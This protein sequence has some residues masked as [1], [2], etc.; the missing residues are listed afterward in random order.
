MSKDTARGELE[1][2]LDEHLRPYI[3]SHGGIVEVVDFDT[4]SGVVHI[5]ME[6][7]CSGCPA[8]LVTLRYGI[9]AALKEYVSWV[10]RV[11]LVNEPV[12]PDF[13]ITL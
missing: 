5:S 3:A 4:E 9:E 11:E 12:E 10:K 13:G 8:S 1:Q 6:G 2:I 7:G